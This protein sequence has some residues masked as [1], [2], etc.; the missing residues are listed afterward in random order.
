MQDYSQRGEQAIILRL[1]ANV[2]DV[3][4]LDIGANDGITYSNSRALIE[5]GARAMLVEP[6]PEAFNKLS[7]LYRD[8]M[9]VLLA[10][11]AVGKESGK[12]LFH[13]TNDSLLNTTVAAEKK[14][15]AG[16][17]WN[18]ILVDCVTVNDL[19]L[20]PPYHFISIDT[21]GNEEDILFQM[22][23]NKLGCIVLCIEFNGDRM[24]QLRIQ[25]WLKPRGYLLHATTYENLIF[26]KK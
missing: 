26:V 19:L 7:D 8:N 17:E 4:V 6:F 16:N 22:D 12:I 2:K 24:K 14:R 3:S 18:D 20:L 5:M 23:L 11:V 13:T 15:W 9:K 25:R 1:L 21:E 10:N